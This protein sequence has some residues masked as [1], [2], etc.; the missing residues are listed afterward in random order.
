MSG[1]SDQ[2]GAHVLFMIFGL[3]RHSAEPIE[4]KIV[5]LRLCFHFLKIFIRFII[6]RRIKHDFL[7]KDR[8]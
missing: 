2:Y 4:R 8:D 3:E 1:S 5:A 7:E 6:F